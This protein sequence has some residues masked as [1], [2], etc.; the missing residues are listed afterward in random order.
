MLVDGMTRRRAL[1]GVVIAVA[2]AGAL[3][4]YHR[5]HENLSPAKAAA[6]LRARLHTGYSFRCRTVHNDGTID[7]AGVDYWCQPIG[8]PQGFGYWIA[9]N[10]HKITGLLPSG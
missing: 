4:L 5:S 3:W 6:A 10:A 7:L 1:L 2:V 8:H 9:T